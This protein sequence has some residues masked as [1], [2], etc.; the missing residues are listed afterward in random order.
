MSDSGSGSGSDSGSGSG[1]PDPIVPFSGTVTVS[2]DA[3]GSVSETVTTTLRDDGGFTLSVTLS[4]TYGDQPGPDSGPDA[5]GDINTNGGSASMTIS[6][7][8]GLT[9]VVATMVE[10][11]SDT[12]SDHE[13]LA[14][15]SG[16]GSWN[17]SGQD[18]F[19]QSE[20][21]TLN[22]DGTGSVS[23]STDSTSTDKY[24]LALTSTASDGHTFT[25]ADSGKDKLTADDSESQGAAGNDSASI[26]DDVHST[27]TTTEGESGGG[28]SVS[29]TST[30]TVDLADQGSDRDGTM[31]DTQTNT[32]DGTD[33]ST[34]QDA[35]TL[36]D[37]ASFNVSDKQS[38]KYDD[39][40]TT[41][42]G[43]ASG[44]SEVV[45]Q[46]GT[47]SDELKLSLSGVNDSSG[48]SYGSGSSSG[49]SSGSG[50]DSGPTDSGT[51]DNITEINS[52]SG[53]YN[54]QET[55][56]PDAGGTLVITTEND[57]TSTF[58]DAESGTDLGGPF[59][60]TASGTGS[61]QLGE[62][63]GPSGFAITGDTLTSSPPNLTQSGT[64]PEY[65]NAP[66]IEADLPHIIEPAYQPISQDVPAIL[67]TM[68]TAQAAAPTPASPDPTPP[69]E[70]KVED[71][72]DFDAALATLKTNADFAN[73][74][75]GCGKKIQY[76]P[77]LM[78]GPDANLAFNLGTGKPARD[79]KGTQI[80]TIYL[81]SLEFRVLRA[82]DPANYARLLQ[83]AITH[84]TIHAYIRINGVPNNLVLNHKPNVGNKVNTG[85]GDIGT[86]MNRRFKLN[87]ANQKALGDHRVRYK[88]LFLD[89]DPNSQALIERIVP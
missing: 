45:S 14:G 62:T 60:E 16:G 21:V 37:G 83:E 73:L 52:S 34:Y 18:K 79:G 2:D 87:A 70:L 66:E 47:N 11:D 5:N 82:T 80:V 13:T 8:V 49:S 54:D 89:I 32:N 38:D 29:G 72:T 39:S 56:K 22:A 20:T 84:E 9:A 85:F 15:S 25:Y 88:G 74:L 68:A 71:R 41:T 26:N 69:T 50:F 78:V 24:N 30:E 33:S 17:A 4:Q 1:S 58:S 6:F 76:L 75:A 77:A 61:V 28:L 51:S 59:S 3:G 64:L 35:G 10:D 67:A 12:F 86:W 55:I 31:T 81:N 65:G 63:Q 7:D 40:D 23:D 48:S 42:D 19:H 36:S 27:E 44:A 57:E 46:G 53:T 43:S